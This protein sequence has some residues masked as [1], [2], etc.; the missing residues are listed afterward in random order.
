MEYEFTALENA[1]PNV[2]LVRDRQS[3]IR[4]ELISSYQN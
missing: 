3:S 4:E 1:V 2:Q